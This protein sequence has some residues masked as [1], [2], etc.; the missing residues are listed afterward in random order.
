MGEVQDNNP[1]KDVKPN[2]S[3]ARQQQSLENHEAAKN[4]EEITPF[5]HA[6]KTVEQ[7]GTEE[8]VSGLEDLPEMSE[9]Q[10][11]QP[12][13]EPKAEGDDGL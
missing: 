9:D 1:M 4:G 12:D 10:A 13:S 3:V 11:A 5:S 6:D 7:S 8:N 2:E